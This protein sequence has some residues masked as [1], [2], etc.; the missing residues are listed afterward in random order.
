MQ[1]E[2]WK[3]VINSVDT[4]PGAQ[5]DWT[6]LDKVFED[7]P[8]LLEAFE[9]LRKQ[10]NSFIFKNYPKAFVK[11]VKKNIAKSDKEIALILDK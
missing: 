8:N 2:Q 1:I 3:K 7:L 6:L 9:R 5:I 4:T 10:R 11:E